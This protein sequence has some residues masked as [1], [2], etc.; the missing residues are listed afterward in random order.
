MRTCNCTGEVGRQ[1]AA[2]ARK[3]EH[4]LVAVHRRP[5]SSRMRWRSEFGIRNALGQA[6]PSF[7]PTG[8]PPHVRRAAKF[9]QAAKSAT[10][11]PSPPCSRQPT[12]IDQEGVGD[13]I[14][15]CD[16]KPNDAR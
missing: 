7:E 3:G 14:G 10:R 8:S 6:Q 16:V 9:R 4:A 13:C 1:V 12:P 5:R 11:R 15:R 2:K